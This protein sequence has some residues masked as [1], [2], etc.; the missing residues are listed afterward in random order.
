MASEWK[1]PHPVPDGLSIYKPKGSSKRTKWHVAYRPGP[2]LRRKVERISCNAKT[3]YRKAL[4]IAHEIELGAVDPRAARFAGQERRRIRLHLD[5]YVKY[6]RAQGN[7][8]KHV[9]MIEDRARWILDQAGIQRIS[10]L[11]PAAV[12]AAIA[13]LRKKGAGGKRINGCSLATCNYYM[14]AIKQFSRWL[15][16]VEKRAPYDELKVLKRF[17]VKTD[18]RH[19]RQD[20]GDQGSARLIAAAESGPD[21]LGMAGKD[22]AMLIEMALE[23]GFR[24]AELGS[25]TPRN[26]HDL[27]GDHPTIVVVASFSKHRREDRQPILKDFARKLAKW[28]EGKAPHAKLWRLPPEPI[29]L[30]KADLD[31]ARQAWLE[32]AARSPRELKKRMESDFL[33]Y[34]SDDDRF[35]DFHALRHTFIMRLVRAGASPKECQ[36]LARHASITQT[37]DYYAHLKINDTA[38]ALR[39]MTPFP[40]TKNR[41]QE[42]QFRATG[43]DD[44]K[45]DGA[46]RKAQR[47]S[48]AEC[49]RVSLDDAV[50]ISHGESQMA[51]PQH[52][53]S[54]QGGLQPTFPTGVEPVTFGSGGRRENSPGALSGQGLRSDEDPARSAKRS[55][56]SDEERMRLALDRI[57]TEMRRSREKQGGRR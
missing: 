15:C 56:L 10:D 40:D 49:R 7:T 4:K 14:R 34:Q 28:I 20:L 23:T 50:E 57:A 11:R 51:E 9:R 46:Q 19:D 31:R 47:D 38:R 37:M 18:R 30:I 13:E 48:V 2:G 27:D 45:A 52:K 17:N 25:L 35:A 55:A 53:A 21:V 6:L 32:E 24:A 12:M 8:A 22:R 1:F 29:D 43:T 44:A 36:L 39:K 41:Q 54:Q 3:T 16:E 42:I 5:D 26:C 33:R